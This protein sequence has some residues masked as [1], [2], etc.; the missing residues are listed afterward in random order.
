MNN[1]SYLEEG[2]GLEKLA[3]VDADFL[4]V[5]AHKLSCLQVFK[6]VCAKELKN[7]AMMFTELHMIDQS[8]DVMLIKRIF[9]H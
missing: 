9:F 3:G 7:E 5:E 8:D 6:Q 4:F 1:M 2:K